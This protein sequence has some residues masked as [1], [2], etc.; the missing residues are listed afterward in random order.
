M[1]NESNEPASSAARI[2]GSFL[3]HALLTVIL[4]SV[5]NGMIS[6][7]VPFSINK[8][9]QS[10]LI[11]YYHFP[12]AL[13]L[14]FFFT[15]VLI[16][17]IQVLRTDSVVWDRRARVAGQVGMVCCTATLATGSVW[18]AAAWN[19]W[20]DW[21]DPR[22]TTAAIMWLTYAGYV[23][24]PSQIPDPHKRR[25]YTAVYGA[26]AFANYPLTK[27]AVE[28]FGQSSHPESFG[29]F[30]SDFSITATRWFGVLAFFS[31]YLLLYRWRMA[32]E[33]TKERLESVLASV[34]RIEEGAAA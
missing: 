6:Q 2:P 30:A 23:L 7:W 26:L 20:W 9:E 13:S 28:L 18:A 3:W 8:I 33:E 15:L 31:L 32:R 21:A 1:A 17:S 25:R 24:L 29:D 19:T 4:V 22:L 11:F 27:Y 12:A 34:R 16:A 14:G 5:F 10:Y